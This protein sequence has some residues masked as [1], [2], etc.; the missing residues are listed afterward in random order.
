[1]SP[2]DRMW[3][4][5]M[6][7]AAIGPL[8]LPPRPELVATVR[9]LAEHGDR[10]RV[11]WLPDYESGRWHMAADLDALADASVTV[12][13]DVAG[14]SLAE[15][16][17]RVT[18]LA[19]QAPPV[20]MWVS[21]GTLL[22]AMR[23]AV[24]DGHQITRLLAET[25]QTAVA[26]EVPGSMRQPVTRQ[27]LPRALWAHFGRHPTNALRLM[28][29]VAGPRP[30]PAIAGTVDESDWSDSLTLRIRMSTPAT[31]RELRAWRA[32]HAA[33]LS[34]IPPIIAAA[35][36]ARL[37]HGIAVAADPLGLFDLRRYVHPGGANVRGNLSVGMRLHAVDPGDPH[38]VHA[39]LRRYVALGRP[40][41]V[42]GAVALRRPT[43]GRPMRADNGA[44]DIAYTHLGRPHHIARLPWTDPKAAFFCGLL[45]PNG[46]SGVTYAISEIGE[47]MNVNVS[48][49]D[50]V[51]DAQQVEALL[52]TLCE[53]PAALLEHHRLQHAS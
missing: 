14:E 3:G 38:I 40:L 37:Q 15:L 23:H 53:E 31:L 25:V 36:L 43:P 32:E 5:D 1:M 20:S 29:A 52:E 34:T 12:L 30:A 41:A 24:G 50:A 27:A 8:P 35:E 47:R 51:I 7:V 21:G 42:L 46:P 18:R 39:E 44:W 22:I 4:R 33:G 11:G 16:L 10:T 26:G 49:H 6:F 45:P 48:F 2:L 9:R 13:P 17:V 28:R 19:S